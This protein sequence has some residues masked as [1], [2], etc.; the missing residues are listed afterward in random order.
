MRTFRIDP[1]AALDGLDQEW[2]TS[3]LEL[4]LPQRR[5]PERL[6]APA[7]ARAPR[8]TRSPAHARERGPASEELLPPRASVS[9]RH[10]EGISLAQMRLHGARIHQQTSLASPTSTRTTPDGDLHSD[11]RAWPIDASLSESEG[12]PCDERR[13]TMRSPSPCRTSATPPRVH[14]ARSRRRPRRR[15]GRASQTF[16]A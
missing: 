9:S 8:Q 11:A 10:A 12:I 16:V 2:G 5:V 4:G 14:S 13:V 7:R 1:P 3:S 6:Q 15:S